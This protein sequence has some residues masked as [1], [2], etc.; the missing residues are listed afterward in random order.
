MHI[1]IAGDWTGEAVFSRKRMS[2]SR[3][4][5]I[6]SVVLVKCFAVHDSKGEL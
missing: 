4:N 1:R 2:H 6:N 3:N 5:S